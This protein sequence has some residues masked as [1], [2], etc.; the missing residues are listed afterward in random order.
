[1][2]NP[3]WSETTNHFRHFGINHQS[4]H[5]TRHLP[6][7]NSIKKCR[8]FCPPRSITRPLLLCDIFLHVCDHTWWRWIEKGPLSLECL[9]LAI[10]APNSANAA[11]NEFLNPTQEGTTTPLP[12]INLKWDS[13]YST[14]MHAQKFTCTWAPST[15]SCIQLSTCC[16]WPC[17]YAHTHTFY[18]VYTHRNHKRISPVGSPNDGTPSMRDRR[19]SGLSCYIP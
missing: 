18:A 6:N 17:A 4:W 15:T 12:S 13:T 8:V 5:W 3:N 7:G 10:A 1:M 9:R 19:S 14:Y 11:M 16:K 2:T